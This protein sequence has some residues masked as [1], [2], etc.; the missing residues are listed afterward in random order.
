MLNSWNS[1][2]T[3]PDCAGYPIGLILRNGACVIRSHTIVLGRPH[4]AP[5]CEL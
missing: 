4:R 1:S 5:H 3:P 2:K